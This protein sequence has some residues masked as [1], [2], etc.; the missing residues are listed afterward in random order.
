M[1][2]NRKA[3]FT[4]IE[5]IITISILAVFT[6]I[7]VPK[8]GRFIEK[9]SLAVYAREFAGDIRYVRQ[10][11]IIRTSED[12]SYLIKWG[13]DNYMIC[14]NTAAVKVNKAPAN[15]SFLNSTYNETHFSTLGAPSNACT[16]QIQNSY[17]D[18]YNVYIVPHTGR[19]RYEPE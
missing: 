11:G 13:K 17:G 4:F 7:V 1:S 2:N 9:Q 5:L 10:M 8:V 18:I 16:I 14:K 6:G 15:I 19:V 12:P 3:G